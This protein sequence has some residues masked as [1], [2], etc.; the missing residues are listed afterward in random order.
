MGT[1]KMSDGKE[2][3]T[4]TPYNFNCDCCGEHI[5]Y[6]NTFYTYD[7][8]HKNGDKNKETVFH[9]NCLTEEQRIQNH[10]D[11]AY[12]LNRCMKNNEWEGMVGFA[13]KDISPDYIIF[14]KQNGY[15]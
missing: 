1:I 14:L 6:G 10:K 2:Y 13:Q 7:K 9:K 15:L 11:F 8:G 3:P 4:D 12:V 5:L